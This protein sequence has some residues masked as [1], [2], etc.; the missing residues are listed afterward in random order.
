MGI[1]SF[2]TMAPVPYL[3]VSALKLTCNWVL[4]EADTFKSSSI[5]I[6]FYMEQSIYVQIKWYDAMKIKS[7][8][9]YYEV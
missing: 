1:E 9:N 4:N 5:L 8:I 2:I 3:V 6:Y 7:G